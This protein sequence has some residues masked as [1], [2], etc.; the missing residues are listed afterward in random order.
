MAT[1]NMINH[2]VI[3]DDTMSTAT[4]ENVSTSEATKTYT[5]E[6]AKEQSITSNFLLM[7]A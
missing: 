2:G 7:G 3:D 1:S 6:K 5:D 4:D